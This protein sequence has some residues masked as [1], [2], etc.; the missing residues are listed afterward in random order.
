MIRLLLVATI[1]LS[2]L[3][4]FFAY[5]TR[6]RGMES[7]EQ[8][9]HAETKVRSTEATLAKEKKEKNDVVA[10]ANKLE[11]EGQEHKDLAERTKEELA[12]AEDKAAK[13]AAAVKEKEAETTKLKADMEAMPK[14]D[15]AK[16]AAAEA[17]AKAADLKVQLATAQQ[18]AQENERRATELAR[19]IEET[20]KKKEVEAQ[21]II[22]AKKE[23]IKNAVGQVVAYNEGWNFVVVSIGDKQGVTPDSQ[24]EV[25]RDGKMIAKLRVTQVQP[26]QS[27]AG[28]SSK[29]VKFLPG[30]TVVFSAA[31]SSASVASLDT[32]RVP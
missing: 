8:R 4:A 23:A 21:K 31:Q 12:K 15:T 19:K 24:L 26:T 7:N 27:T 28:I 25:Q 14:A 30:D 10:K 11:K 13:L 18:A 16:A 17:E 9:E 6:G 29:R 2:S 1:V 20:S 5:K 22:T 3:S 32:A